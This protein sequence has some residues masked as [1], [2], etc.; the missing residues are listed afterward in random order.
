V[1]YAARIFVALGGHVERY[2]DRNPSAYGLQLVLQ[3]ELSE[4]PG[5]RPGPN[6]SRTVSGSCST[7]GIFTRCSPSPTSAVIAFEIRTVV[8]DILFL[9]T[10][11]TLRTITADPA[12]LGAEIGFLTVL[13][14]LGQKLMHP[15]HLHGLMN[16][17]GIAPD[18]ESWGVLAG[19]GFS[20]PDRVLSRLFR[21][22]HPRSTILQVARAIVGRSKRD[23]C[24]YRA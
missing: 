8:Y 12:H 9:A 22:L 19:W 23:K 2:G 24:P 15:P 5:P 18:G 10:W 17:G 11:E 16:G 14:P 20:L 7:C 4:V 13:H 3:Q 1:A 21:G 6:G